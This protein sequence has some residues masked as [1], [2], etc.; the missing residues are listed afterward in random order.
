MSDPNQ[1][2]QRWRLRRDSY[3]PA[4]E[5]IE[6]SRYGVDLL[7]EDEAKA[8]VEAHH[9]S[10]TMPAAR[11]RVGLFE[12]RRNRR[13]EL[14]GVAVFS[15]PPSQAVIPKW[16]GLDPAAGVEL[17]RLV[18]LDQ[19]PGNGESWFVARAFELIRQE[20][21]EVRAVLS[22]SDPVRRLAA[23]GRVILP[24]HVGTVYQAL[25]AV[26]VGRTNRATVY[27][28]PAGQVVS[29]RALSKIVSGDS[30]AAYGARQ[31]LEAGA[32]ARL[33]GESGESWLARLK[34]S[35]FLGRF[36][37]PGCLVYLWP[38]APAAASAAAAAR[39]RRTI[40]AR[41]PPAL[42]YPKAA[43]TVITLTARRAG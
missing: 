1:P 28:T 32:P 13:P 18:L 21:P 16:T 9:Y 15:V 23:D 33:A 4:G 39:A 12:A 11:R 24:G 37:H 29:W 14:V 34:A 38:M 10:G 42:A 2:C 26:H 8:F 20:L 5:L 43:D 19:V 31:L 17:G 6:T 35:G 3:R 22:C 30:G 25:N 36:R 7:E 41:F 27:V 40:A